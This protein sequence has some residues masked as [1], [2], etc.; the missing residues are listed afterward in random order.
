[1][2]WMNSI[3]LA[4]YPFQASS[5]LTQNSVMSR[6]FSSILKSSILEAYGT[7]MCIWG[8]NEFGSFSFK[9]LV[10]CIMKFWKFSVQRNYLGGA[11][12]ICLFSEQKRIPPVTRSYSGS[13]MG[14]GFA[15][16]ETW[17]QCRWPVD[18]ATTFWEVYTLPTQSF[19]LV[20]S[21]IQA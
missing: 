21:E 17:L 8:G 19:D 15:H 16:L 7:S 13:R 4:L 1:M 18:H 14:S 3:C 11:Y 2:F 5:H 9:S 6:S 10:L 20:Q 12:Y